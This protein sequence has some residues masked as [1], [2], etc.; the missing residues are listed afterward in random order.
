MAASFGRPYVRT[1]EPDALCD[2]CVAQS[3]SSIGRNRQGGV[4][5]AGGDAIWI[6][7]PGFDGTDAEVGVQQRR[8]TGQRRTVVHWGLRAVASWRGVGYSSCVGHE[9]PPLPWFAM[10]AVSVDDQS[11][12][13][14]RA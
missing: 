11:G 12:V 1:K 8:G 5:I 4:L 13:W 7:L 9:L 14:A 6:R 3:G 10:G 2:R